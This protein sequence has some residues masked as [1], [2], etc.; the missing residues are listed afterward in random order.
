MKIHNKICF[1]IGCLTLTLIGCLSFE[2]VYLFIDL[3]KNVGEVRYVNIVSDSADEETIKG[4]FQALI[5]LV[6]YDKDSNEGAVEFISKKLYRKGT[7][8]N[9][10]IKFSFKEPE[11]ALNEFNIKI[12]DNKYVYEM[13]ADEVYKGG[14]GKYSEHNSKKA[15][16]WDKQ[17]KTIELEIRSASFDKTKTTS[18]L[19]HWLEWR[20]IR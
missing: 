6:Y 15:V 1:L 2:E 7:Q 9:G 13:G 5:D 3:S 14:N 19:S 12:A 10:T 16:K 20:K 17:S 11:T 8:L 4:D 18:L